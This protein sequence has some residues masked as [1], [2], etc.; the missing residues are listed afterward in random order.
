M[1]ALGVALRAPQFPG[2]LSGTLD[3]RQGTGR[4]QDSSL[5]DQSSAEPVGPEV[6][7]SGWSGPR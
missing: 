6:I 2:A 7:V 4:K 3:E 1:E 5:G